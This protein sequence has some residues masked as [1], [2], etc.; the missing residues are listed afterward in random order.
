MEQETVKKLQD[1]ILTI[2]ETQAE[3]KRLRGEIAATYAD[4]KAQ[5][6][7]VKAIRETVKARE[8]SPKER[9]E[10]RDLCDSYLSAAGERQASFDFDKAF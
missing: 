5:G 10:W 1:I 8:K 7:N 4:A 6:Y 3:L 2:E 9:Q